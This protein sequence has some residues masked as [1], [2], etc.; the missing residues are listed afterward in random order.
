MVCD[1]PV[2]LANSG[3]NQLF[4][5]LKFFVTPGV[6]CPSSSHVEEMI[7]SAGGTIEK[8]RK[9]IYSIRDL[10]PF[11]YFIISCLEDFHLVDDLVIIYFGII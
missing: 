4:K 8:E 10:E 5:N 11:T 6:N 3:R 1:V 9:S 2:V 7:L